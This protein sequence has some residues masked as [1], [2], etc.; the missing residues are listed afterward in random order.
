MPSPTFGA[1]GVVVDA[2][3]QA[4]REAWATNGV[5]PA[6]VVQHTLRR[7]LDDK[8][9]DRVL[10]V[11]L[12]LLR[13]QPRPPAGDEDVPT[14]AVLDLCVRCRKVKLIGQRRPYR[15]RVK[16]EI[17]R[18]PEWVRRQFERL[19]C[20]QEEIAGRLGCCVQSV[21]MWRRRHGIAPPKSLRPWMDAGVL[22]KL[23][24]DRRL[25]PGTAAM[26]LGCE[27]CSIRQWAKRLEILTARQY[28]HCTREWWAD[29]VAAGW[30]K[31]EMA[32]HAG[33]VSH[34]ALF[35]LRKW[36]LDWKVGAKGRKPQHTQLYEPGWLRRQL[37]DRREKFVDVARRVG[38]S[39]SAVSA[40]AKK[41][42]I[43][44]RRSRD[45]PMPWTKDPEWYRER[46]RRR[47]DITAMAA[48]AGVKEKS[49]QNY[50]GE[51]GLLEEY[52]VALERDGGPRGPYK[53]RAEKLAAV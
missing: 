36:G 51:L 37:V 5:P 48:E 19:H 10:G 26:E 7:I 53:R 21:Q 18:D 50:M 11:T 6:Q 46:F 31:F 13:I 47:N 9:A 32:R 34:A 12:D 27:V 30:T 15:G 39:P 35:H 49:I 29:R 45:I 41:L 17:L 25:A 22:K 2:I 52:W 38:C 4:V 43:Y 24:V 33:I 23:L 16:M 8:L 1:K 40:A 42:G 28:A 44:E 3:A 20:S 14:V